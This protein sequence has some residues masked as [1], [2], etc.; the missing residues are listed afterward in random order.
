MGYI[1]EDNATYQTKRRDC[2][3]LLWLGLLGLLLLGLISYMFGKTSGKNLRS[4]V[5]QTAQEALDKG[6]FGY[7]KAVVNDGLLIVEGTAPDAASK[8]A[9]C[10]AA[11][12]AFE[13][14]NMVGLPGIVGAIRCDITYPGE[15]V[16]PKA[17]PAKIATKP[18]GDCQAQL[19]AAATGG[20][21]GFV[22]KGAKINA[23][24][25]M[26]DKVA[27]AVVNCKTSKIEVA[28]HTDSGGEADMNMRLSQ[29]RA[30]AVKAYLV[31]KGVPADQLSAKGY[32]ETKPL[33]ADNAVMGVDSPERAKNRRIEFNVVTAK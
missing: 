3:Y 31:S 28:G 26:L 5:T 8:M 20:G 18:D 9:A 14:K 17:E 11:S 27:A 24:T 22:L 19:S 10:E 21:V 2:T 32:G 29:A 33:V 12:K 6:N 7:A 15:P 16:K 4:V 13:G 23:G 1:M 30:D 25:E